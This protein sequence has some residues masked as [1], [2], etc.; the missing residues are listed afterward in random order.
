MADVRDAA[1]LAQL[2][3]MRPRRERE[4]LLEP[5]PEDCLA[6]QETLGAGPPFAAH[7]TRA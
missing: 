2:G 1:A 5:L 3:A 4:R 7:A 6:G